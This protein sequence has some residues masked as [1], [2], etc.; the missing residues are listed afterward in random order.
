MPVLP[1]PLT[2]PVYKNVDEVELDEEGYLLMNGYVDEKGAIVKRPGLRYG[3]NLLGTAQNVNGLFWWDDKSQLIAVCDSSVVGC[4]ADTSFRLAGSPY[5]AGAN[6]VA[7]VRPTFTTDGTNV[8]FAN[9]NKINY[10]QDVNVSTTVSQIGSNAPTSVTQLGFIDGYI[11]ANSVNSNRWYWSNVNDYTTWNALN[12]ASAQGVPDPV[13]V[14][15]VLNRQIYLFGRRSIEIWENDGSTPFARVSN[16]LIE[17]GCIAPYSVV[18]T[19]DG[20]IFLDNKRHFMEFKSGV[21]SRI[22]SPYDKFIQD[23][24]S[25]IVSNPASNTAIGVVDYISDCIGDELFIGGSRFYVFTFPQIDKTICYNYTAKTWSEWGTWELGDASG[26]APLTYSRWVGN[27]AAY[28]PSWG[29]NLIGHIKLTKHGWGNETDVLVLDP[30]DYY[31]TDV[32][33]AG[34]AVPMKFEVKTGHWDHRNSGRKRSNE[35]RVRMK[36]GQAATGAGPTL[37]LQVNDD[38]KGWGNEIQMNLGEAGDNEIVA[39]ARPM[40]IYRTRQYRLYTT[41]AVPVIV[42]KAEEDVDLLDAA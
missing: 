14:I 22:S 24:G 10:V 3:Q 11:I 35:V 4:Y 31:D 20:F 30:K 41:D 8:F 42:V 1:I 16:G 27:C 9:G 39:R 5:S 13:N 12:F 21:L 15:R 18:T 28:S 6:I 40:G 29:I 25:S 2:A 34:S 19:E 38:N 26:G 33:F 37:I 36:R 17:T 7:R 32:S 23:L